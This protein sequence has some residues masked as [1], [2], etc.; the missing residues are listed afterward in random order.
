M[1][2]DKGVNEHSGSRNGK[3]Q[4]QETLLRKNEW[5]LLPDWIGDSG[6]SRNQ[7]W[8]QSFERR[9]L[10]IHWT[11][12]G[13][14]EEGAVFSRCEFSSD[15]VCRIPKWKCL[16][17]HR[18]FKTRAHE[19]C[20][21]WWWTWDSQVQRSDKWSCRMNEIAKEKPNTVKQRPKDWPLRNAH[22]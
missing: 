9:Q 16:T 1:W 10:L 8:H 3:G 4:L 20:F 11:E 18:K 17:G 13:L 22:I 15:R 2:V 19:R 21:G 12:K 14:L 5:G 6:S 7:R